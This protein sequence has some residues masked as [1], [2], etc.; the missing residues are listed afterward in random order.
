M[1][2]SLWTNRHVI[3]GVSSLQAR[4]NRP[5]GSASKTYNIRLGNSDGTPSWTVHSDPNCDVA[6]I[7][8]SFSRLKEDSIDFTYFHFTPKHTLSLESAKDLQVSEGDGVFV[9]GFPLGEAGEDRNYVIVRQG[10]VARIRDWLGGSS[11][12]ILIDASVFPGNS[13]G[14]VI[15]KPELT[16]I[17]GTKSN[18]SALLAGM[19]SGYLHYKDIA[20]SS[21]T[22]NPRIVFEEN[23]GLATVVPIDVIQET[24]TLAV[25]KTAIE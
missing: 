25:S 22:G 1:G 8:A 14:P 2:Y 9:L 20:V 6:V 12:I 23:S 16:S 24:L 3:E 21:Q 10:I 15:L 5:M 7:P 13:G 18:S 19:V 11:R 17:A 4:L